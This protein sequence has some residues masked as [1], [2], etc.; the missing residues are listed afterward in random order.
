M[1][2]PPE[3][4]HVLLPIRVYSRHLDLEGI[5]GMPDLVSS[6]FAPLRVVVLFHELQPSTER[7]ITISIEIIFIIYHTIEIVQTFSNNA[8]Y[9]NLTFPAS[10]VADLV[11]SHTTVAN[12]SNVVDTY[13]N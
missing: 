6:V 7:T 4:F 11:S 10:N 8:L 3:F 2:I 13:I 12:C 9:V 5:R 1:R